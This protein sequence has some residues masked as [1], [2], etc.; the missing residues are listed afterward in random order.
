MKGAALS[1]RLKGC[2]ENGIVHFLF[3]VEGIIPVRRTVT[4]LRP[5]QLRMFGRSDSSA[6][7]VLSRSTSTGDQKTA[8]DLRK[9]LREHSDADV[10]IDFNG[11]LIDV[12]DCTV[13]SG[14]VVL[15]TNAEIRD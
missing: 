14:R 6:G 5:E 12:D 4:I 7:A 2:P 11:G 1:L 10:Y 15:S 3:P 9:Q 13:S 8:P